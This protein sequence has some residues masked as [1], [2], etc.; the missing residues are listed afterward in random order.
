MA[1]MAS[2]RPRLATGRA[3][4]ADSASSMRAGI[5]PDAGMRRSSASTRPPG[6]TYLPGMNL[7]PA[8]RL[9]IRTFGS[10]PLRSI[11]IS[12]AAS[13]GRTFGQ[14]RSRLCSLM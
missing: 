14:R 1:V 6:K 3:I 5:V 9:P 11:R 8:C 13:L 10:G 4:R 12:V 2:A 7:W